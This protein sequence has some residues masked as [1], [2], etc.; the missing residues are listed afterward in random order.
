MTEVVT[1]EEHGKRPV[2]TVTEG[3][4]EEVV[5]E[6]IKPLALPEYIT[7]TEVEEIREQVTVTEEVTK[8]GKPKKTTKKEDN[9]TKRKEATSD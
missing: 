1:V 7:P 9:Q 3:P 4:V 5:E 6:V 8:E 2:T